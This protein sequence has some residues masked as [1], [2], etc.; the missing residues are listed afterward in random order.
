M[1]GHIADQSR[2][3]TVARNDGL[4]G[5]VNGITARGLVSRVGCTEMHVP[6]EAQTH[7]TELRIY[8]LRI[9]SRAYVRSDWYIGMMR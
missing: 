6:Y 3:T 1:A 9:Q 5:W 8:K 4:A 2:A 7:M